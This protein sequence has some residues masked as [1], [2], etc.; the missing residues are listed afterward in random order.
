MYYISRLGVTGARAGLTHDLARAVSRVR[1]K[2]GKPIAVG[3]GISTPEQA[4]IV[5][6]LA[7]GVVVGSALV[8]LIAQ[9]QDKSKAA[10]QAGA[11]AAELSRAIK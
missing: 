3:F 8:H 5:A 6:G 9:T 7:E 10:R 2:T 4:H 1:E 11:F